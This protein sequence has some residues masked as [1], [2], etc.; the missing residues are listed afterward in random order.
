[1]E[2]GKLSEEDKVGTCPGCIWDMEKEWRKGRFQKI[3]ERRKS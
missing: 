1:M 2:M 3:L